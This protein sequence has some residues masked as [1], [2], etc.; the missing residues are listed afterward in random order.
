MYQTLGIHWG[1]KKKDTASATQ[2]W[3]QSAEYMANGVTEE[4]VQSYGYRVTRDPSQ[5][6]QK[7]MSVLN[8]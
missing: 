6:K 1:K 4:V 2:S 7:V 8:T 5:S 3:D